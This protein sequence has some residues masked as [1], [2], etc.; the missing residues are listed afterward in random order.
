MV[1]GHVDTREL[2]GPGLSRPCPVLRREGEAGGAARRRGRRQSP[3]VVRRPGVARRG[4]GRPAA[5]ERRDRVRRGAPAARGCD[6]VLRLVGVHPEADGFRARRAARRARR[7][8]RRG[9]LDGG[10]GLGRAVPAG[11][12]PRRRAAG[13]AG[14]RSGCAPGRSCRARSPACSNA[15]RAVAAILEPAA[16][17]GR[18]LQRC[19]LRATELCEQI[20]QWLAHLGVRAEAAPVSGGAGIGDEPA[21]VPP[22]TPLA[23][24]R[25]RAGRTDPPHHPPQP[26]SGSRCRRPA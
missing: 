17:R 9:R 7:G 19:A 18:E 3:P 25:A 14:C 5:D 8:A 23:R 2:P 24:P 4:R 10:V 11:A 16:A 20:A 6:A 21:A 1:D 12:A 22:A 13:P 15:C 26:S